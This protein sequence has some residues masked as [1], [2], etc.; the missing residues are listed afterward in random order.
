[1]ISGSR[2][3]WI[4]AAAVALSGCGNNSSVKHNSAK[5]NAVTQSRQPKAQPGVPATPS[6]PPTG[7][8]G[9]LFG[10]ATGKT[11][12][13]PFDLSPKPGPTAVPG[14]PG[15]VPVTPNARPQAK[16][17][18]ALLQ[19]AYRSSRSL[20][21]QGASSVTVKQDGKTAGQQSNETFSTTYKAPGKFI[22]S[23][24]GVSV[25]C[26]GKNVSIYSSVAKRYAKEP[27]TKDFARN[28]V[29]SK[30]GVG[31]MG[32]LFGM[33]YTS[34][35]QSYKLLPDVKVA[36]QDAFALALRF[37]KGAGGAPDTVLTQTLWIG[38]RDLCIYRN[39][40]VAI[41]RPRPP[42]GFKGKMPKV[43]ETRMVGTVSKFAAN[44][45]I[46]DSA[47]VFKAPSGAKAI[48]KPKSV[49]LI[50]KP[51]P[52]F[53]FTWTDGSNKKL[54]DFKGKPVVLVFWAMPMPESEVRALKAACDNHKDD[55]TVIAI[56]FNAGQQ[57]KVQ[58]FLKSKGC[59]FPFVSG[60]AE[61][62][63]IAS[64]DYGLR[65][66]PSVLLIDSSGKVRQATI[67]VPEAKD[68]D[69]KLKE[70]ASAP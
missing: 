61:I 6:Q 14:K 17:L 60:N 48:E 36:G 19:N 5:P 1:M 38:K 44:P 42:K 35:I 27:F 29:Y 23:S 7:S 62:G 52:D 45:K 26:D 15:T 46:S 22:I 24:P 30:P 57:D 56:N 33:D 37:K 34:G 28:L 50:G 65:G 58:E 20:K 8:P 16:Q 31:I 2:M 66:I 47:F 43:M 11:G 41:T 4:L 40:V 25:T 51:A 59:V 10:P 68:M 39:E 13:N 49:N 70:Y 21:V 3:A 63:N 12:A 64:K 53:A 67:G 9:G 32:L 18:F 69:V 54:S 55:A